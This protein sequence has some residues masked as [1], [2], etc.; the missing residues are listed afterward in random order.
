MRVIRNATLAALALASI[1]GAVT[2]ASAAAAPRWYVGAHEWEWQQ[3]EKAISKSLPTGVK[4]TVTV[5]DEG[6]SGK[7]TVECEDSGEGTVEPGASGTVTKLG[8]SKCVTR[9]GTCG[10]PEL[11]ATDLPW[12]TQLANSKDAA[13]DVFSEDGHGAPGY[14]LTCFV[15]VKIV[16]T[17]TAAP[18]IA[19]ST[20]NV[21]AGVSATFVV[22]KI[23]CSIGG[24]GKG[25]LKGTQTIEAGEGAKLETGGPINTSELTSS[26]TNPTSGEMTISDTGAPG[27]PNLRCH[28]NVEGTVE[29]GGKGTISSYVVSNCSTTTE[30][31]SP[32]V[33]PVH[34][35]W[36]TELYEDAKG[37]LRNRIVSGGSGVPEWQFECVIGGLKRLDICPIAI[38]ASVLN[39]PAGDVLATFEAEEDHVTCSKDTHEGEAVWSGKLTLAPP[40]EF[41]TL[42]VK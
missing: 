8:F 35:P 33:G 42:S 12:K 23:N 21:T 1:V 34:L 3:G 31:G 25:V 13:N 30:C 16:D 40:T 24:E 11:S 19:A 4:G 32:V 5:L 27:K 17:C 14:K 15:L 37:V 39:Q 2:T 28:V 18:T 9:S 20:Q 41:A 10:S 26:Y 22:S 38:N 29:G 7:P 36:S 6:A